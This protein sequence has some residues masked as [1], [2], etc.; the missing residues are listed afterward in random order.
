MRKYSINFKLYN[1]L[2][3]GKILGYTFGNFFGILIELS[4]PENKNIVN[5]G[6]ITF[7]Y[8]NTINNTYEINDND[9]FPKES[10]ISNPIR[11]R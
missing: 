6:F 9:F 1:M 2:N 4:S 11:F 7:G 3:Y 8:S 5:S 10:E